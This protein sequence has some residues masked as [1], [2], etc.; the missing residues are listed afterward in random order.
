[1]TRASCSE[2]LGGK[3]RVAGAELAESETEIMKKFGTEKET[4][5]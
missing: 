2:K 4:M 1:M 5:D 3:V